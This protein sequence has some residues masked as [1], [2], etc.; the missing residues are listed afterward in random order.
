[1]H[2]KT[3]IKVPKMKRAEK[4]S[5]EKQTK[6]SKFAEDYVFTDPR[7]STKGGGRGRGKLL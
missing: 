6:I 2:L 3:T 1:M 7:R 5:E 4:I